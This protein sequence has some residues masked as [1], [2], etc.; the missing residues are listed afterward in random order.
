[1]N[2]VTGAGDR[3]NAAEVAAGRQSAELAFRGARVVD[4]YTGRIFQADVAV[5][6]SRI[7]AVGQVDHC[8]DSS[9]EI[10]DCRGLFVLPGFVEPHM[11]IGG[12]QLTIER[13]AE[14]LVPRGTTSISTCLYEP[15]VIGGLPAV[16]AQLERA[17]GTGLDILLS[18]FHAASLGLGA[19]G[20]LGRFGFDDLLALVEREGCVELREWNYAVSK[21]PIPELHE[22]YAS[23]LRRRRVIGGHLE[24]LTGPILQA[25][26]ALGVSSDH[27]TGTPEDAI[28][29]VRLGVNVQIREGSGA[30]DLHAL[31]RAITEHG[32]DPR[33]FAF[34][35]DEQEL[36]SLVEDG[37]ID[38][39]LCLAV[40]QGVAPVEAV[41][42]ATLNPARCLGVEQEYGSVA[43]GRI[44][45]LAMVEDLARFRVVRVVSAGQ[46]SAE[47]GAYQ[48]KPEVKPY[49]VDWSRTLRV[50]RRLAAADFLLDTPDGRLRLRVIGLTPGSLVTD[51]LVES[52]DVVAGR[53]DGGAA[54]LAKIAVVDRHEGGGR[55]AVGLIRGTGIEGGA[56]AATVNPGMMNLMVLGVDEVDMALA[57]NRVVELGGGIAVACGGSI[58][59]EVALPLFGI[60]SEAPVVQ[61]ATSCR[62]IA[63]AIEGK[64]GSPVDGLLT[65][66][67]FACL[68]VSIPRLKIC[69]RGLVRVSRDSQEAA[70]L[71][72]D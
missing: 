6:G 35:T 18:P 72:V 47:A 71:V 38:H 14:V 30:R 63:R 9:T 12:S 19:F 13:L 58:A 10:L 37:H 4:V 24:G 29:K 48:L 42:M 50:D 59:A 33:C 5:S 25:S 22:V 16:E 15:A 27:E 61:T 52:V 34:C 66:A 43:P 7:A 20:N 2:V 36:S 23:A 55:S 56:L 32:M 39:K 65:G 41:R 8:I 62:A 49:P 31:V 60:L 51:E 26:V 53:L 3:A 45:S 64:L 57:A 67:G 28:E 44:A 17:K 21:I 70:S 68:A 69:D 54:G 11:H 40:G 1:L 46:L